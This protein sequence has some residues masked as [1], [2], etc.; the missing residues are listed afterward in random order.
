MTTDNPIKQW[1]EERR[2]IIRGAREAIRPTEAIDLGL[3][4]LPRALDALN[5]VLGE[6]N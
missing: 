6:E 2:E 1:I 4:D 5:A 3:I